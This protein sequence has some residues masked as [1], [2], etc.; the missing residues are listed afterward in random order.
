MI[1]LKQFVRQW[2][3]PTGIWHLLA[4]I[5]SSEKS[6]PDLLSPEE[7]KLLKKNDE[8]KDRHVGSRCFILGAGSSVK[9]QDISK[10]EGEFIIS[11]SNTF[12]HPDFSRI[13]PR[14]HVLPPLLKYHGELHTEKKFVAWLKAMEIATCDAEMFLHI[15]DRGMVERNGLFKN[16]VIH[17]VEYINA[18]DESFDAPINLMCLPPIWS[19][20][21]LALT[22]GVY[23]GFDKIYLI[24]IDH[25]WFNGVHI[26]FYD[27]AKEHALRPDQSDLN[28]VDSEFQMRRHANIFRKYKYLN[29]IRKNI[30]NSN[31][32]PNHYLDV[33][34]R[35]DYDKLF[36]DGQKLGS[37]SKL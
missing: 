27:H 32:N 28:F 9:G 7:I 13:K 26:Y 16:R 24:G 5:K 22:A 25:D 20:S 15:G 36:S 12:V 37:V 19:V 2:M 3:I 35:A 31:A 21:E 8:L 33:F 18:W 6:Q 4:K 11:V 30:Y 17:W 34:P 1:K 23:L 29:S 14:Y 10:L